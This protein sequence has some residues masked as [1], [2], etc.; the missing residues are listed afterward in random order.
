MARPCPSVSWPR[1]RLLQS[2]LEALLRMRLSLQTKY[3]VATALTLVA[4]LALFV[5][6][7]RVGLQRGIGPY[8][9]EIELSR[10]DWMAGNLQAAY[11]RNG[12]WDFLRGNAMAWHGLQ[13]PTDMSRRLHGGRRDR[14]AAAADEAHPAPDRGVNAPAGPMPQLDVLPRRVMPP[15]PPDASPAD[16]RARPDSLY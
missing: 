7:S 5:A 1:A 13:W 16:P 9:A 3:F 6:F 15:P 4:V 12:S 10:L 11:A 14:P 8:V 2:G